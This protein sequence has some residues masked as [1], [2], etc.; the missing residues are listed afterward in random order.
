[1][2]HGVAASG[3]HKNDAKTL[4]LTKWELKIMTDSKKTVNR[5]STREIIAL[6]DYIRGEVKNFGGLDVKTLA[7]TA[8]EV[9]GFEISEA[10]M[11]TN[12]GEAGVNW[13]EYKTPKKPRATHNKIQLLARVLED[14]LA[15]REVDKKRLNVLKDIANSLEQLELT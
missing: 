2:P 3:K 8:T 4:K 15:G 12:I 7:A 10:N 5:L 14:I 9:L 13:T 6:I 11:R 1:M